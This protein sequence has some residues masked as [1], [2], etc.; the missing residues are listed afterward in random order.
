MVPPKLS[1]SIRIV[2]L[3]AGTNHFAVARESAEL[4]TEEGE[5]SLRGSS[6]NAIL[7]KNTCPK[8]D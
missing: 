3:P 6:R 1:L 2:L 5:G 4:G 8:Y 7:E